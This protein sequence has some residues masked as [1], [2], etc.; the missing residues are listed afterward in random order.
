MDNSRLGQ[1][2]AELRICIYELVLTHNVAICIAQ[3]DGK[4]QISPATRPDLSLLVVCR[5]TR[6]E[7][8]H[9]FYSTNSFT[10]KA[11]NRIYRR[12][13]QPLQ[14]FTAFIGNAN[15]ASLRTVTVILSSTNAHDVFHPDDIKT[16]ALWRQLR[17]VEVCARAYPRLRLTCRISLKLYCNNLNAIIVDLDMEDWNASVKKA[18]ESLSARYMQDGHEPTGETLSADYLGRILEEYR[19]I[20]DDERRA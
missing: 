8:S 12:D 7:C 20:E 17:S 5:Q 18:L 19:S 11:S 15:S 13:A 14:S 6:K 4:V 16:K 10:I 1:L 3:F 2:T 9:L